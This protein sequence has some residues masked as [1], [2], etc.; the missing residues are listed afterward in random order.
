MN[1]YKWLD[2]LKKLIEE[3]ENKKFEIEQWGSVAEGTGGRAEGERVQ[4]TSTGDTM[5]VATIEKIFTQEELDTLKERLAKRME[6]LKRLPAD[7]Y[8][9]MFKVY[10]MD[11]TLKQ[12]ARMKNRG[13]TWASEK[14]KAAKEH[15]QEILNEEY[16]GV[17]NG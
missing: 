2:D 5:E 10:V 1:V 12:F 16:G 17:N 15:L 13:S 11:F 9:L 4:S 8:A 14:H 6:I 3:I 7:E